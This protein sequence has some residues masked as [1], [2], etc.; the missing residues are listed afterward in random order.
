MSASPFANMGAAPGVQDF[1]KL[2]KAERD[3]LEF[4]EGIYSWVGKDVEDRVLRKYGKL[5]K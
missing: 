5:R 4:A 2:F 1:N 3:N